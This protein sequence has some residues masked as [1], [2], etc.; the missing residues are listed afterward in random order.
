V[1]IFKCFLQKIRCAEGRVFCLSFSIFSS[2]VFVIAQGGRGLY[3][4]FF[5]AIF[6]GFCA[7]FVYSIGDK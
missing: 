2:H 6:V 5:G 4:V 3:Q 1:N 7:L